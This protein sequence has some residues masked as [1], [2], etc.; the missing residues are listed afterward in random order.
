MAV[1]VFPAAATPAWRVAPGGAKWCRVLNMLRKHKWIPCQLRTRREPWRFAGRCWRKAF[2]VVTFIDRV[3]HSC[4][5]PRQPVRAIRQL[6]A[7]EAPIV[8][9][10]N[11]GFVNHI[12]IDR[13][14]SH[15][16][17]QHRSRLP[18]AHLAGATR[19]TS[20][21]QNPPPNPRRPPDQPTAIRAPLGAVVKPPRIYGSVI[22]LANTTA[23]G[24]CA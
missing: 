15:R 17:T 24:F 6:V 11:A 14:G 12:R 3:T 9:S 23:A 21:S 4:L 16:R 2:D 7:F 1:F 22:L 13:A 8:D 5:L 10:I 19:T 18:D 20:E